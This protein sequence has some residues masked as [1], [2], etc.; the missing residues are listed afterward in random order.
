MHIFTPNENWYLFVI[1]KAV[2]IKTPVN[3]SAFVGTTAQ[4][5]CTADSTWAVTYLVNNMTI[6][7]VASHAV[8]V[9]LST[10]VYSGS[11]TSVYLYVLVTRNMTNWSVVCI[12]Y[13]P[14]GTREDSSPPAYLHVQGLCQCNVLIIFSYVVQVI[15]NGCS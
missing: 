1:V 9:S 13:L 11:Q 7:N 12:A 2:F 15:E 14:N 3:T 5:N 8:S 6:T 4:F 10:P